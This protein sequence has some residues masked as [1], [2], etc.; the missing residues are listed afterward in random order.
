MSED[1]MNANQGE[2]VKIKTHF[3][4]IIVEGTAETPYYSILYYDPTEGKYYNGYGSYF[5]E[6]VF[7][8]LSECFE[9]DEST[10][11]NADRI[12]SMSDEEL[13][14]FIF[15]MVDDCST[16]DVG[17]YG[18]I[19]YGTHHSDPANKGTHLYECEGCPNE[20]VGLDIAKWLK[21]PVEGE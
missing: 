2:A 11:T 19:N 17:C 20:A 6:N 15:S 5:I 16:H 10:Y 14:Q 8:W 13:A 1:M 7:G 3:A 4:K 12:R 18:C 21:Q 9:I